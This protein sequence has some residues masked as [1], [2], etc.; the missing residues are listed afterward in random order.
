MY[1]TWIGNGTTVFLSKIEGKEPG[2][3]YIASPAKAISLNNTM[4]ASHLQITAVPGLTSI[5]WD[6]IDVH[7]GLRNVYGS[8]SHDG[9]TF[10]SFQIS[11]GFNN[12]FNPWQPNPHFILYIERGDPGDVC[13]GPQ[14]DGKTQASANAI[15]SG[16][17]PSQTVNATD[18]D[19]SSINTAILDGFPPGS[20]CLYRWA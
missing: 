3:E 9:M 18:N 17:M 10:Y 1:V 2:L 5:T 16:N 6:A 19:L 8:L 4:N 13:K 12:A 15:T 11:S 7:T 14:P 20:I